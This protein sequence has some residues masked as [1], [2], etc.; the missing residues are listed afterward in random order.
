MLQELDSFLIPLDGTKFNIPELNLLKQRYSGACSWAS[1]VNDVLGKFVERS[2]YHNIVKE[3]TG[4]LQDG[5]SLGV[6]GMLNTYV[7]LCDCCIWSSFVINTPVFT[8]GI[9]LFS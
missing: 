2:D 6:K 5:K 9:V 7:V 3:L 1:H 4:I 8:R